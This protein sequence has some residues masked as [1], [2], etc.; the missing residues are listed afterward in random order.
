MEILRKIKL[1]PRLLLLTAAFSAGAILSGLWT[2]RTLSEYKVTGPVY[3]RII[4]NKDLMADVL[5]P[6]QYIIESYLTVRELRSAPDSASQE[7]L[8]TR[9]Q[10]LRDEYLKR[11]AYWSEAKLDEE[12]AALLLRSSH[13]P[14]VNFYRRAFQEFVPAVRSGD[15][16]LAKQLLDSMS[17]DF[18]RH[19]EQINVLVKVVGEKAAVNEA[20]SVNDVKI[21]TRILFGVLAAA[22]LGGIALAVLIGRSITAPLAT[23]LKV[24][25][26]VA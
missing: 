1:G 21:A 11:H 2:F 24:A 7:Q 12:V 9:L 8:V 14:V 25:E 15:K 20:A 3:E 26:T 18:Y 5:P 13:Q 17:E 10:K 23:S 6:P 22:L 19:V 16:E 4:Q